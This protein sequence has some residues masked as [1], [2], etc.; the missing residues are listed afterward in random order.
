MANGCARNLIGEAAVAE[1][2]ELVTVFIGTGPVGILRK[3]PW[4]RRGFEDLSGYRIGDMCS[5]DVERVVPGGEAE[6]KFTQN[7]SRG[8]ALSTGFRLT[9]RGTE[10]LVSLHFFSSHLSIFE[11]GESDE[12]KG[13]RERDVRIRK[14]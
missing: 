1:V 12:E 8:M 5:T 7:S 13:L 11:L 14:R 3:Q 10:C 6:Q 2:H 9:K 4:E